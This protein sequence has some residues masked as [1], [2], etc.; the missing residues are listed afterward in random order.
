MLKR[1]IEAYLSQWR[2]SNDKKP[3]VIKGKYLIIASQYSMAEFLDFYVDYKR[4]QN[5]ETEVIYLDQIGE[6]GNPEFIQ[7][8][9]CCDNILDS[10]D[11]ATL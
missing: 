2:A 9:I 6:L 4:Q 3:I 5:Y 1:K 10:P 7:H 8:L 11:F